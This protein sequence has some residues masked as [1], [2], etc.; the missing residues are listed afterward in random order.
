MVGIKGKKKIDKA[1]AESGESRVG[2]DNEHMFSGQIGKLVK[3]QK[4]KA[5][6][7]ES[8]FSEPYQFL[9]MPQKM[10][11]AGTKS[12]FTFSLYCTSPSRTRVEE[13]LVLLLPLSAHLQ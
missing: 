4:E 2:D 10:F 9:K 8:I 12:Q 11:S 5:N 6:Y 7:I 3:D 1:K 13:C